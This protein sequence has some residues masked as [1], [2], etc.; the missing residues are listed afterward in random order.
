[1]YSIAHRRPYA[2]QQ[3]PTPAHKAK[4]TQAWL[5]KNTPHYLGQKLYPAS[6]PDCNPLDYSFWGVIEAMT[7]KH[8]HDRVNTLQAAFL[9]EVAAVDKILVPSACDSIDSSL[10]MFVGAGSG[11]IEE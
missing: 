1:M 4:T 2:F 8:A 7:N 11:Y 5:Y 6:S 10:E 3:G 9:K